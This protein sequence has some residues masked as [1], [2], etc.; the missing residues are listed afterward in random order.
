[1]LTFRLKKS[2][3]GKEFGDLVNELNDLEKNVHIQPHEAKRRITSGY[4]TVTHFN[5]IDIDCHGS[6][7]KQARLNTRFNGLLPLWRPD[8]AEA[9]FTRALSSEDRGGDGRESNI[10]LTRY[11]IHRIVYVL[12]RIRQIEDEEK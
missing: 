4:E 5:I 6:P 2:L 10:R 1:M 12:R 9:Q 8:V 11:E 3:Y 7:I